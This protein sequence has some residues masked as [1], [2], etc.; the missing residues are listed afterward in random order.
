MSEKTS[1]GTS[2][3]VIAFGSIEYIHSDWISNSRLSNMNVAVSAA[4]YAAHA[5]DGGMTFVTK[6][7]TDESF[8]ESVT[9]SSSAVVRT[10]FMFILPVAVLAAGI[11]VFVK[12][13]NA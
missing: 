7:I 1:D 2:S 10:V 11:Y 13:R 3:R 5:E 6:K 9:A 4:E 12:R 8:A